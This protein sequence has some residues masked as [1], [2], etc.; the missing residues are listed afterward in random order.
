MSNQVYNKRERGKEMMCRSALKDIKIPRTH[1]RTEGRKKEEGMH[2]C[3]KQE[4]KEGNGR[5]VQV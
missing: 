2:A 1:N 4:S 5:K 3:S